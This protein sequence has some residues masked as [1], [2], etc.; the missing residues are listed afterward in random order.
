M[1]RLGH[2]NIKTTIDAYGHLTK[3]ADVDLADE[4]SAMYEREQ[5]DNVIPLRAGAR[6]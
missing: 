2:R 4:L 5:G 1:R 6:S 3:N